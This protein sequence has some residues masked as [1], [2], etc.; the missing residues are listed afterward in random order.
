MSAKRARTAG[1][2][3]SPEKKKQADE[4]IT[5]TV[6]VICFTLFLYFTPIKLFIFENANVFLEEIK[7]FFPFLSYINHFL[8][9]VKL[10]LMP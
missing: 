7:D 5:K 2:I 3:Q 9:K 1:S 10:I 8:L 4:H 6:S